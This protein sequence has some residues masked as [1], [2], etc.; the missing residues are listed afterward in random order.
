MA[1]HTRAWGELLVHAAR[2]DVYDGEKLLKK[3][4]YVVWTVGL[5]TDLN[6]LNFL[7]LFKLFGPASHETGDH[8]VASRRICCT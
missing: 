1:E 7:K 8:L 2:C 5:S 6:F 3:D 4:M